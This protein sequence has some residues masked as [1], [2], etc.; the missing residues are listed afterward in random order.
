M[1]GKYTEAY[2]I[3]KRIANSNKKVVPERYE[4]FL[5]NNDNKQTESTTEIDDEKI[6]QVNLTS[7]IL[8]NF[9]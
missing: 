8:S 2:N 7:I 3:L 1:R 6:E 4:L 5:L 9:L